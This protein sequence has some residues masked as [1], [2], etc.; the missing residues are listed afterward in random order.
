[1]HRSAGRWPGDTGAKSGLIE[2]K[3]LYYFLDAVRI[4]E[5]AGAL[6]DAEKDGFRGWLRAYLEWLQTSEQGLA[7]RADT[8]QPRHLLRSSD[9]RHRGVSGD[10]E[11]LERT[12]LTSRERILEQFTAEG[13]QPHEMTRTQTAHYCCFNLQSWVNL[14]TLAQACGHDLWSFE[15]PTAAAWRARCRWLLPHM[16]LETGPTS[17]SSPST[18][19]GSSPSISALA[20]GRGRGPSVSRLSRWNNAIRC[21]SLMTGSSRSGCSG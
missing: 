1:M 15:G 12:F 19:A 14:A 18:P 17:R 16:A 8:Q 13:G 20:T 21:S 10:A 4:V 6:S 3:D 9:R 7:E 11:V 5:R 2:M